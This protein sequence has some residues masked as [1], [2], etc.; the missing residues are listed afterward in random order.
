MEPSYWINLDIR[1]TYAKYERPI[2]YSKK[3]MANIQKLVEG[4][5][6]S[7]SHDENLWY[8]RKGLVIRNTRK[9]YNFKPYL[10]R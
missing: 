7:R 1:N 10:L 9:K 6:R 2:P 8:C 5:S 3:A 4:H